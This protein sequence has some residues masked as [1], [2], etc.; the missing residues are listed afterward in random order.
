MGA[1][2]SP[3]L[4][5]QEPQDYSNSYPQY[6]QYPYKPKTHHAAFF[7]GGLAVGIVVASILWQAQ[8]PI[9]APVQ[10]PVLQGQTVLS[11][12]S[13]VLY[14]STQN[15]SQEYLKNWVKAAVVKGLLYRSLFFQNR[16]RCSYP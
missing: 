9:V 1:Y 13:Q 11:S 10:G 16:P 12:Q 2:G 14:S 7:F 4:Y 8:K 15:E 6:S 5:P 3:E